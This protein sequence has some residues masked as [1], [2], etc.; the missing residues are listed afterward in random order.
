MPSRP[1]RPCNHIGCPKTV[2]SGYCEEHKKQA[3]KYRGSFRERG[4]DSRWDKIRRMKVRQDPLCEICKQEDRLTPVEI[5][6]HIKKVTDR[7]DLLLDMDN[8]KS[9]CRACH[10]KIHA[11]D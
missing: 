4:Y 8:L 10:A 11:N 5:V 1:K 9:V 2:S 6:H 3:N 7:P